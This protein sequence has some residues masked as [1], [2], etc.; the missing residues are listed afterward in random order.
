MQTCSVLKNLQSNLL[1]LYQLNILNIGFI[2]DSKRHGPA[3]RVKLPFN[4][5]YFGRVYFDNVMSSLKMNLFR[6]IFSSDL[7]NFAKAN[8]KR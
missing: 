2:F 4:K 6:G 7:K 8:Q 1:N 5:F 3:S